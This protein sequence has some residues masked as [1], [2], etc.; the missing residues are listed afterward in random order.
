MRVTLRRIA[1]LA[2]LSLAALP[3]LASTQPRRP[4]AATLQRDAAA[5]CRADCL[6]TA[7]SRLSTGGVNPAQAC[8]IR[9]GAQSAFL[10]RQ[11]Q[12][13]T[14]EATGR[15]RAAPV[16]PMPVVLG[17]PPAGRVTHGAIY[18]ARTPSGAYGLVVG[19]SDRLAAHASAERQCSAGGP[20]CRVLAQFTASC[21]A[22]AQGV[23]RSGWAMFMTADPNTYV[24]TSINAGSGGSQPAAEQQALQECR[25]R[26]PQANCRVVAAA[27]GRG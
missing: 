16:A 17:A 1:G 13:G 25:N 3:A 11:G 22:V 19:S 14:A 15:G 8:A 18:G 5:M 2:L 21:G 26:D 20:G 10:A 27:C 7:A 12:R 4:D 6:A 24:V 23:R 9:C